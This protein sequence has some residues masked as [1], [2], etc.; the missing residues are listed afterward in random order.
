MLRVITRSVVN[1]T[2]D[3]NDLR[4]ISLDNIRVSREEVCLP[5]FDVVCWQSALGK[6]LESHQK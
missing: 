1:V 2:A 3:F 4:F 6:I 5:S